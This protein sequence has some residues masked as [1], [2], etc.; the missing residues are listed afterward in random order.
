[1]KKI[2][3]TTFA[4]ALLAGCASETSTQ[5][6]L[7]QDSV[8]VSSTKSADLSSFNFKDTA[9]SKF[10]KTKAKNS[11]KVDTNTFSKKPV[12]NGL[13]DNLF[14]SKDF[15]FKSFFDFD[16]Y[17]TSTDAEYDYNEKGT[18][19]YAETFSYDPDEILYDKETAKSHFDKSLNAYLTAHEMYKAT[20]KQMQRFITLDVL[21]NSLTKVKYSETHNPPYQTN[22]KILPTQAAEIMPAFADIGNYNKFGKNNPHV[23]WDWTKAKQFY[24]DNY[25]RYMGMIMEFKPSKDDAY[26][27]IHREI[28]EAAWNGK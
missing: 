25:A 7:A 1:M 27:L 6:N 20:K 16:K 15:P 3:L 4:I 18:L 22:Y 9:F 13:L 2:V 11:Y 12:K 21:A 10:A 14:G 24:R 8:N 23:S 19:H 28:S 5:I 26:A 17:L